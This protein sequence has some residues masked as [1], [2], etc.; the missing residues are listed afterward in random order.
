M[1]WYM[2]RARTVTVSAAISVV[3]VGC[4]YHNDQWAEDHGHLCHVFQRLTATPLSRPWTG[5]VLLEP[6]TELPPGG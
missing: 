5:E 3:F 4:S 2:R 1:K 6:K